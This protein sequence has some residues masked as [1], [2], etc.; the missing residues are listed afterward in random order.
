MFVSTIVRRSLVA[1]LCRFWPETDFIK[2][3]R[4]SNQ[5]RASRCRTFQHRA[6]LVAAICA[7]PMA[8]PA[9]TLAEDATQACRVDRIDI[10]DIQAR[11]TG[12]SFNNAGA[13]ALSYA[14]EIAIDYIANQK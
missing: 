14:V 5:T 12:R 1:V 13:L 4:A 3:S 2:D 8:L 9:A 6:M 11:V 7:C 10:T